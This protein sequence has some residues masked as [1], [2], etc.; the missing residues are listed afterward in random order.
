[1]KP[2]LMQVRNLKRYNTAV[3]SSKIKNMKI[4]KCWIKIYYKFIRPPKHI[5]R[6][7]Y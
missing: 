1:M 4:I 5:V 7:F 3:A 2:L 6:K